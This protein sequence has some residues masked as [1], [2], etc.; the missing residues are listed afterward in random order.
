MTMDHIEVITSVERRRRW[1]T[2]EKARLVAAMDEPGAVVTEIARSAGV[3]ASLLYRW[4]RELRG[5]QRQDAGVCAGA[6]VARGERGGPG[7]RA[8]VHAAVA[9]IFAAAA[10]AVLDH[11][12]FRRAGSHDDRRRA[13]RG[14]RWRT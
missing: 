10:G 12:R 2:A 14:R 11:D 6:G 7:E 3:C 9:I 1:S 13:G 4:R 5:A 8:C